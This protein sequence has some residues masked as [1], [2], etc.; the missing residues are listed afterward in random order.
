MP[1]D[2]TPVL[3]AADWLAA[4]I[5]AHQFGGPTVNQRLTA[6]V[7]FDPGDEAE[8]LSTMRCKVY[9]GPTQIKL[10]RSADPHTYH[11]LVSLKKAN[12]TDADVRL[13]CA[14][15]TML[16]DALRSESFPRTVAVGGGASVVLPD[17]VSIANLDAGYGWEQG[18]LASSMIFVWH[19]NVEFMAIFDKL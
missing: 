12:A 9:P 7:S 4:A 5:T 8:Q 11:C 3:A 15:G 19:V 1:I 6:T 2:P 13:S 16:L 10:G 17:G 14:V 18:A